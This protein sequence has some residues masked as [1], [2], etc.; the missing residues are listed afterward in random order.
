MGGVIRL[1][2]SAVPADRLPALFEN[3]YRA[4][5]ALNRSGAP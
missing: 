1:A 5:R 2:Y 3:L 4:A